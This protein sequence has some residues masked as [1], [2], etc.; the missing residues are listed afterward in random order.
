MELTINTLIKIILVLVVIVIVAA[1]LFLVW[2]NYLKPYFSGIGK[3][4]TG[5][6][7]LRLK[8]KKRKF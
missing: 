4:V 2:Q 1:S 8:A 5:L 7:L 6:I 3:E